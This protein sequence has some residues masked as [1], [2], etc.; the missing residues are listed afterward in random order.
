MIASQSQSCQLTDPDS[1][2][3][4]PDPV[5]MEQSCEREQQYKPIT[6]IKDTGRSELSVASDQI[7]ARNE[8]WNCTSCITVT[9]IR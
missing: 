3:P 5:F 1:R 4:Q 8:K 7:A 6:H 9:N 2:I